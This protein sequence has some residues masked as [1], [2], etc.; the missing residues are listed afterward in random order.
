[1]NRNYNEACFNGGIYGYVDS[2][3]YVERRENC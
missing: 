3:P 2:L 1:M